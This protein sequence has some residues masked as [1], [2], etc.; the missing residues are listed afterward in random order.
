MARH[1]V[2]PLVGGNEYDTFKITGAITDVDIDKPV[3]ITATDEVVLCSD[4]DEIYGFISSI[5][6]NLADGKVVVGVQLSGRKYVILDGAAA[7]GT[8]VEA[9]ANTAAGTAKAGNYGLVSVHTYDT[10]TAI[11]LAADIFS[12]NWKVISGTWLDT[13]TA[14]IEKQ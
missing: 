11:T 7:V 9:A 8:L 14:L 10:T 3:A 6:P 5:E 12:K 13:S 4:G 1:T 2:K